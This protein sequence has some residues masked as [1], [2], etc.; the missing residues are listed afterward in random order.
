MRGRAGL[1]VVELLVALVMALALVAAVHGLLLQQRRF[2]AWETHAAGTHDDK[3]ILW[4]LLSAD[5]LDAV[6]AAGDLALAAPDS[7]VLRAFVGLGFACSVSTNPGVL[8]V[9]WSDGVDWTP[10][11]SLM[12]HTTGGWRALKPL[13]ELS[14]LP[15]G[16]GTFS[17]HAD[18]IYTLLDLV[19]DAIP[20]GAPVR[21]FRRRAYHIARVGNESWVART[22]GGATDLLVGPLAADG[23]RFGFVNAGGAPTSAAT[24]AAGIDVVAVLDRAPAPSAWFAGRDTMRLTIPVRNR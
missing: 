17:V 5:V 4:T 3:R 8:A 24:D 7:L 9:A 22:D 23:L 18:H 1:T 12:V 2:S 15:V 11:D 6:P 20:V 13:G 16:C 10:D 21:V 19:G 14:P